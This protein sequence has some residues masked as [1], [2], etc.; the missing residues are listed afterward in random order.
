MTAAITIFAATFAVFLTSDVQQIA[1]SKY[2]MLVSR[3]LLDHGTFVLDHYVIP[4]LDPH[5]PAEQGSPDHPYQFEL[6][7]G[8]VYYSYPPGSSILSIPYVALMNA[9]GISPANVDHS[10]NFLGERAIQTGL[11]ALL[12]AG[13]ATTIFFTGRLL[14]SLEWSAVIALGSALGTQVWSTASRGLWS[15]TWGIFLQ[16]FVVWM[17]LADETGRAGLRPVLLA[18]VLS[19][20]YF[21]RPTCCIPIFGVSVY[22]LIYYRSLLVPYVLTGAA[23]CAGFVA[24]SWHHFGHLLPSYYRLA[25]ALS[26][27]SLRLG[28]LCN[29]ISPSRGLLVFVPIVAF[30]A[31]LLVRY[32]SDLPARGL[33]W[34]SV[35][36]IAAHLITVSAFPVWWA[37]WS[38]GPRFSTG[39][40]PWLALLAIIG[41]K[42]R[43][44]ADEIQ[45]PM[46]S[47]LRQAELAVAGVLLGISIIMNGI[48]ANSDAAA[49]WNARPVNVDER[50]ERVWD[51]RHPQFLAR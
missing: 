32:P 33:V 12:M 11:A 47:R 46:R 16:G 34:L 22:V 28:L 41:I 15:D 23:W 45:R 26:V 21:V 9:F 8:H 50:P 48:G 39:L 13:L 14:L 43:A 51:W 5:Q 3:S 29:L 30:V 7:N 4:G 24:Y 37:G 17:L 42:A 44:A 20:M 6:V 49:A 10:F 27:D 2:S 18:S 1:D 38:Y 31:Y 19:W 40:V 25:T 35:S 36:I